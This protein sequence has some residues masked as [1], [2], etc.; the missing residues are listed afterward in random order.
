MRKLAFFAFFANTRFEV[1]AQT[2]FVVD[3][4][5]SIHC[6]LSHT[7]EKGSKK[8]FL[9]SSFGLFS[10]LCVFLCLHCSSTSLYVATK[11][12]LIGYCLDVVLNGL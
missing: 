5:I 10:L 4:S 2:L 12:D 9:S 11:H 1:S 6:E 8:S 7:L 3:F